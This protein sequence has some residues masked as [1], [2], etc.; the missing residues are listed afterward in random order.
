MSANQTASAKGLRQDQQ[1]GDE[2][3]QRATI[4]EQMSKDEC[5]NSSQI[6]QG[7]WLWQALLEAVESGTI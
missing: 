7:F 6:K 5:G 2:E 3:Q 1:E 4:A